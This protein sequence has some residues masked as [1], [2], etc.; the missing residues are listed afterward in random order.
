MWSLPSTIPEIQ[1]DVKKKEI[2]LFSAQD[3]ND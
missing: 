1:N 2:L 3:I